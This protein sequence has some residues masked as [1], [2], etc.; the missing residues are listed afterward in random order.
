[1]KAIPWILS[2]AMLSGCSALRN[3][4]R[5]ADEITLLKLEDEWGEALIHDDAAA[6]DRFLAPDF[7]FIEPDGTT[8]DRAAYLADRG[9]NPFDTSSFVNDELRVRWYGD[10]AVVSGHATVQEDIE[11]KHYA[12]QL[13]WQE[14][15]VKR[16]GQWKVVCSQG[17][18]VNPSWQSP[19][20]Q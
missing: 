13:R 14:L 4:A 5:L 11:G 1:M 7:T 15:W 19:F 8:K 16:K 12:F 6:M 9:K 10:S 2:V 17:T 3:R 18:P 20:A